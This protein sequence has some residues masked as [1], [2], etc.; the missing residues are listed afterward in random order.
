M[1]G[2]MELVLSRPVRV[3]VGEDNTAT[4]TNV[5]KGYSVAARYMLRQ[6]Q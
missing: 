3:E 4:I 1:Q 6:Q 5:K 2:L